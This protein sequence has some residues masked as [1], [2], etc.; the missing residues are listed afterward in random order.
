M[1]PHARRTGSL[2]PTGGAHALLGRPGEGM[3]ADKK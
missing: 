3:A 1:A 2:P